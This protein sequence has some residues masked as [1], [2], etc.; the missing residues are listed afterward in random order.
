MHIRAPLA[1]FTVIAALGATVPSAFAQKV[2]KQDPPPGTLKAGAV[3][4]VDD[5]SCGA[6]MIKRITG[7]GN[8][9]AGTPS[10]GGGAARQTACVP[11]KK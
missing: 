3:V 11:R 9:S 6:G 1:T 5:G 7:G 10:A 8:Y 4:L 2:L